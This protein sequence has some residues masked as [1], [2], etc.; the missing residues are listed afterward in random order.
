M[1]QQEG[2]V[3][4]AEEHLT[5]NKNVEAGTASASSPA[6]TSDEIPHARGPPVVGVEDMGLQDGKGVEMNL[7]EDE[8]PDLL[9]GDGNQ[10]TNQPVDEISKDNAEPGVADKDGDIVL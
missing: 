10:D 4:G 9:A 1:D 6:D 2:L 5:T 7:G 8:K 3:A